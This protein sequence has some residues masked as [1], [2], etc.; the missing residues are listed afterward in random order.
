MDF[1]YAYLYFFSGMLLVS[2]PTHLCFKVPCMI[3][4]YLF[5]LLFKI[6]SQICL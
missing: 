2:N 3:S 1:L 4:A 6:F 5:L